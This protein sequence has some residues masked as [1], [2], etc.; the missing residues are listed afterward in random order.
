MV[1]AALLEVGL[2]FYIILFPWFTVEFAGKRQIEIYGFLVADI[3]E[4]R[5]GLES[6]RLER[7]GA[8]R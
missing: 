2:V 3:G 6:A 8:S 5:Y 1:E 4:C 7:A